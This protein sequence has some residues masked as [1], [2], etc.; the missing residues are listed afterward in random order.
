MKKAL[1]LFL[2][3]ILSAGIITTAV[4]A[5]VVNSIAPVQT[6]SGAVAG[7]ILPSGVKTWLGVPYAKAPTQ[8]LRWKPPQPISW[9]GVYNADRKMPECIQVLRPHNINHYFGEEATS[10]NCLFLNVWAPPRSTATSKLPVVVF[11][12]GGGLTIGSSGSALYDGEQVAKNGVVYVNLNYRVGILGF[13][14]HP[15]LTEEQG[16]HSGNYGYLD[17]V[18]ALQWIHD[19]IAKFGGDP[20]NVTITGQSAGAGSVTSQIFSPLSRGLFQRAMMSSSCNWTNNPVP[21]ASGEATGLQIQEAMHVSNLA[22]MRLMPADRI[23]ALQAENQVGANNAGLRASPVIDGY[24]TPKTKLEM[25]QEHSVN[26]VPII[27]SSNGDDMAMAM[28]ALVAANNV[29]EYQAAAQQLFGDKTSEFLALYP[30]HNDGEVKEVARRAAQDRGMQSSNR[31][32]AQLQAQY[33]RSSAYI[34]YFTRKH[35]Y[36]AGAVI[37]DQ[38]PATIGAYHTADIP[39]WF[40]TLDSFNIFRRT[41]AWTA[42]DRKM[43]QDMMNSLIAFARTGNP[44]TTTFRWPAWNANNEQR[45]VFGNN[46][47]IERLNVNGMEWL[48]KNLAAPTTPTPPVKGRAI[49]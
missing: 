18:A 47:A 39:F 23:M 25:L 33:L 30:V 1:N 43:S 28:G 21:L 10:E 13:M 19:N 46:I 6:R 14:A 45:A 42:E 29:A 22:Q 12:H 15:E 44:S 7:N 32:C 8:D 35:S 41:R 36:E 5:Q 31:G 9:R 17:Q 38:N 27:A 37:A 40:G 48:N 4:S 24:F 11:I 49:D 26:D 3:T 2:T 20:S 16:G 34:G